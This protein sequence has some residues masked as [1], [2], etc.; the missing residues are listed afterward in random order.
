MTSFSPADHAMGLELQL[1]E[2]LE[3]QHRARVQ[4]RVDDAER[5]QAE[6]EQLQGELAATS[7][8]LAY[9]Q[10]RLEPPEFHDADKLSAPDSKRTAATRASVPRELPSSG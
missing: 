6:I 2:V 5:L 7:E 9:D 10:P 1:E 4:G 3:Q 8:L